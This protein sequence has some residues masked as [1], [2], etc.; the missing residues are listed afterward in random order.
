M[1]HSRSEEGPAR[2]YRASA[3]SSFKISPGRISPAQPM[4]AVF[5]KALDVIATVA[6]SKINA[7]V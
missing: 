1:R 4:R 5:G 2:P 6:R 3:S 7:R